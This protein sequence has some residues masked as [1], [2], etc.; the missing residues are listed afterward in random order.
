METTMVRRSI[1]FLLLIPLLCIRRNDAFQLPYLTERA[2][3]ISRQKLSATMPDGDESSIEQR[4]FPSR[5]H[6][7]MQSSFFTG[8][9]LTLTPSLAFDGGVGG[10][11]KTK[12]ETG[13]VLYSDS[14]P[15]QNQQGIVSA[16]INVGGDPVLVEFT[17]PWPLLPTTSGLEARNLQSSESAFVSILP[18]TTSAPWNEKLL[19]QAVLDNIFGSQGKYGSFVF[20][21]LCH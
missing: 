20:T 11:G 14:A 19:K 12:P 21:I 18:S 4:P 8:S 3:S 7:L 1:E 2:T 15:L 16:E 5:F 13:V 10:L 9:L 6:F 17:T